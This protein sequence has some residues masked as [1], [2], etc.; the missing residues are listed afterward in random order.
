MSTKKTN[1]HVVVRHRLA[2]T[3]KWTN[4]WIDDDKL[5]SIT[6]TCEIGSLC[7]RAMESGESVFV[8]RC[9]WKNFQPRVCCSAKV[10]EVSGLD[11]RTWFVKFG[12]QQVL[13]NEPQVKPGRGTNF[14][15]A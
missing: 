2:E 7:S 14:Y 6:T 12:A 13:V 15:Q 9:A 10:L 11:G 5:E 4:I 3:Q 8:H 1:L